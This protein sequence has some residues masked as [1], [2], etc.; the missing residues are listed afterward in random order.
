MSSFNPV[1]ELLT[2]LITSTNP[3]ERVSASGRLAR[4]AS[5]GQEKA[6]SESLGIPVLVLSLFEKDQK[7]IANA[8]EALAVLAKSNPLNGEAI[9]K[10]NAI[11]LLC[12][13]ALG[14]FS[15]ERTNAI[16]VLAYLSCDDSISRQEILATV[17]IHSWVHMME[18]T[19]LRME[20]YEN[21]MWILLNLSFDEA[22][23]VKI[24][25]CPRVIQILESY[26]PWKSSFE[27][28]GRS[29]RA[30]KF[31]TGLLSNLALESEAK[32]VLCTPNIL[33]G[34][35]T[36]LRKTFDSKAQEGA[37]VVLGMLAETETNQ[38]IMG[39]TRVLHQ[40]MDSL[41]GSDSKLPLSPLGREFVSRALFKVSL[42][43]PSNSQRIFQERRSKELVHG[44]LSDSSQERKYTAAILGNIAF[45]NSTPECEDW[46]VRTVI[47]ALSAALKR[48]DL[49]EDEKAVLTEVLTKICSKTAAPV[50]ALAFGFS[51]GACVPEKSSDIPIPNE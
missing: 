50:V 9:R 7:E 3:E 18:K 32:K 21:L 19:D 39:L 13:F 26:L 1:V 43:H 10:A 49:A 23:R 31:T 48:A 11:P 8:L 34:L 41:V 51:A 36:L 16:A 17:D 27:R 35:S 33:I 5:L 45:H 44:L 4:L 37:A 24:L 46:M 2:I 14:S 38:N 25:K 29:E 40:L 22:S 20:E 15:D 28:L 47:P 30:K 42:N 12:R 6:I